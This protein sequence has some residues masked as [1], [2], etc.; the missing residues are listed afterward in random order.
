MKKETYYGNTN[1]EEQFAILMINIQLKVN[2]IKNEK[3]KI[4]YNEDIKDIHDTARNG[5]IEQAFKKAGL[6]FKKI[7]I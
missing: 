2:K 7:L 6:Y 1:T 3:I 4:M 5:N